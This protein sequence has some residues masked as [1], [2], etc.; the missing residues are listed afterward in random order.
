MKNSNWVK[1]MFSMFIICLL[2]V[3]VVPLLAS[4]GCDP[5]I[6]HSNSTN[7]ITIT[8]IVTQTNTTELYSIAQGS[9]LK[10]SIDGTAETFFWS[11]AVIGW[12]MK[13]EYPNAMFSDVKGEI[14]DSLFK[15]S[16]SSTNFIHGMIDMDFKQF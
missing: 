15:S 12:K 8:N 11:G 1:V 7:I 5:Q 4:G 16:P 10:E 2:G 14:L 9:Q 13:K 6:N 3:V